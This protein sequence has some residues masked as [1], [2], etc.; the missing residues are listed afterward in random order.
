MRLI[1]LLFI[2]V[3]G[4]SSDPYSL[5]TPKGFPQV[6]IPKDN[7]LSDSKIELGKKLFF[8]KMMS[9]DS[10]LSCASCHMP[11]FA[12]SDGKQKSTGIKGRMVDRNAPTLTNVAYQPYFMLD[13][14]NPSL[15]AQVKVPIHEHN[16]FDFHILLIA[17]RM[18]QDSSYKALARKAFNSLP[19]PK[20]IAYSLASYQ[21]TLLSG[22]SNYDQYI[23]GNESAISPAQKR[24]MK[25]FFDELYC[26]SCHSGF[27]FSDSRLTNNGLYKKYKDKGRARLTNLKQDQAIFKVP[28][29]RNIGFTAPYMHDGSFQNLEQV[30]NHYSSGA[31]AHF[32]QD[33]IIKPFH[34]SQDQKQD[35]IAFLISLNDSSFVHNAT[36]GQ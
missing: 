30:I 21:R 23:N 1:I 24:G 18:K 28:T 3:I 34:L 9:R 8:D 22:N 5:L 33:T 10:T 4:V 36:A 25:L 15:E 29:L 6:Y 2:V 35:L 19:N 17:Q 26:A 11:E 20:V 27:N 14:L 16:E 31:N 12:F 7:S 13:G 32:N